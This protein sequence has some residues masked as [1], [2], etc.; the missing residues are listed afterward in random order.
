MVRLW[1]WRFTN[2]NGS[3]NKPA[4]ERPISD[5]YLSVAVVVEDTAATAVVRVLGEL[6]YSSSS[7]L[8]TALEQTQSAGER[9]VVVDFTNCRYIDSTVL[10]VLIRASKR[11]G[12]ALRIV[13][14]LRSHLRRIFAITNLDRMI[15]IDE[16]L[17][18]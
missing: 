17:D 12:D 18:A 9:A 4:E 10:T 3:L 2:A 11:N 14:P 13:I 6:D 1:V 15:H 16:T 8:E 7:Q 5:D